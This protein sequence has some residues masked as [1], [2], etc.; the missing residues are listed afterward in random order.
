MATRIT[1][2]PVEV[3]H[4]DLETSHLELDDMAIRHARVPAGTDLGPGLRG[5]PNDRCP[6]P[7]WGIGLA[8]PLRLEHA[9][10][11]VDTATAGEVYHWPA[12]HP[13]TS[14]HDHALRVFG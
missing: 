3:A 4:G 13:A 7:H 9:D 2:M 5:L 1:D 11:S 14:F 8:G 12:G 6:R 10:G